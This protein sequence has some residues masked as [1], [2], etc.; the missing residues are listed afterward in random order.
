MEGGQQL[1]GAVPAV[2]ALRGLHLIPAH[3]HAHGVEPET[4]DLCDAVRSSPGRTRARR[5]PGCRT[6][7]AST[8]LGL[9]ASSPRAARGRARGARGISW[10][11]T[12]TRSHVATR[13]SLTLSLP[14]PNRSSAV[15][16]REE[17]DRDGSVA[18]EQEDAPQPAGAAVEEDDRRER[19]GAAE[20]RDLDRPEAQGQRLD[21]PREERDRGYEE[22]R[23]LA[24]DESAISP[25][26]AI[27]PRDA[28]TTAP[29]CSAAFPTIATITA[30]TKKSRARPSPRTTSSEPTRISATS[31]VA[32]V[33]TPRTR[34]AVLND[35]AVI[36]S[37]AATC[38]VRCRRSENQVTTT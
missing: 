32:S 23:D 27:F 3:R 10:P 35:Q 15:A 7:R 14:L 2:H 20:R 17:R 36:S 8:A 25:A 38:S 37:S 21:E 16:C 30:A 1:V 12:H 5:R 18:G 4:A 9:T 26:S 28:T 19:D 29:P 6:R 22:D 33:A 11:D 34:S 13:V 24:A 31:A